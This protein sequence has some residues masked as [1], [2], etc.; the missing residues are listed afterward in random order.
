MK[1]KRKQVQRRELERRMPDFAQELA[2]NEDIIYEIVGRQG[3]LFLAMSEG[4][5]DKIL[6]EN[7]GINVDNET[8]ELFEPVNNVDKT[9]TNSRQDKFQALKGIFD[10]RGL[11]EGGDKVSYTE[12]DRE[13]A[14][15]RVKG[16]RS[17][18]KKDD[19]L[20]EE[21]IEELGYLMKKFKL[22]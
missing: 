16:L 6:N 13:E 18:G 22:K 1:H 9:S 19:Y 15:V 11:D 8:G 14:V 12:F 4:F 5:V 2:E 21:E 20:E 3:V 10:I 7:G 17:K